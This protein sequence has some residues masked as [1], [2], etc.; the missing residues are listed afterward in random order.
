MSCNDGKSTTEATG[1]HPQAPLGSTCESKSGTQGA[2]RSLDCGASPGSHHDLGISSTRNPSGSLS[3]SHGGA[4]SSG[5][6]SGMKRSGSANNLASQSAL[7]GASVVP[8]LAHLIKK[9]DSLP[10]M[11]TVVLKIGSSSVMSSDGKYVL[12][13]FYKFIPCIS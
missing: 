1:I 3:G 7:K 8:E 13:I 4:S 10:E 11:P 5:S 12:Q 2:E 6:N 9:E